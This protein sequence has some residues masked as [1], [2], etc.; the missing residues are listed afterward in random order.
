MLFA[1]R[2]NKNEVQTIMVNPVVAHAMR[3]AILAC[4]QAGNWMHPHGDIIPPTLPV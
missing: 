4:G 3:A 2:N 1:L